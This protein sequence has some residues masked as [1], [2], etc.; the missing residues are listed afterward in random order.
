[1]DSLVTDVRGLINGKKLTVVIGSGVSHAVCSQAPTWRGLIESGIKRCRIVGMTDDW[2]FRRRGQLEESDLDSLLAVAE[3]VHGKLNKGGELGRWLRESFESLTADR[4]CSVIETL[5]KLGVPLVT[6]NYDALI[7]NVTGL[8]HVTWDDRSTVMRVVRGEDR[9]VLHLHGHWEKAE[10][11]VL[12]IRSYESVKHHEHTQTVMK[13]FGAGTSLLFV[14]CGQ[15]GLNDPN[16]GPFLEW[17]VDFDING[18]HE[19]RHYVMVRDGDPF[20]KRGRIFPLRYGPDFS[21]LAGFLQRLLPEDKQG[22]EGS[23][24]TVPKARASLVE[25]SP[26]VRAY[27]QRLEGQTEKLTLTGMGRGIPVELPIAEAYV[28]LRTRLCRSF[29]EREKDR[30]SDGREDFERDVQLSDVF[31]FCRADKQRGALLLGEPG[32]GKTT[33]ARQLA[34]QLASGQRLPED[35][36]LPA[37]IAPVLL[38]FRNLS[39]KL[40]AD[41][42]DG[43]RQFLLQETHSKLARTDEQDPGP[44]LWN[45]PGGLLWILD[46]L[47]EVMDPAARAKVAGWVKDALAHRPQDWFLVTSRFQGYDRTKFSL[48]AK[49]AEFE[50]K[51]LERD[52]IADFVS[53]WFAVVYRYLALSDAEAQSRAEADCEALLRILDKPVN[54]I[55]KMAELS[56]N[57]LLLTILCIVFYDKRQ[58]PTGRAELYA[59]CI[60]VLLEDWRQEIYS[61]GKNL[62]AEHQPYDAKAAQLVL[63]QVAWWMHQEQDRTASSMEELAA[64]AAKALAVL[65]PTAGLGRDGLVFV[66]RM[67]EEA[68]ILAMSGEGDGHCGFLHKTFQEYLAA[69]YAATTNQAKF[70]AQRVSQEWWRE[71]ALLSLRQSR[72]HCADFFAEMLKAGVAETDPGLAEQCLN[73]A[74]VF[75]PEPFL[76]VLKSRAT[77]PERR[78]AVLRLLRSRVEQ[79]PGLKEICRQ[80]E[81]STDSQVASLAKEIVRVRRDRAVEVVLGDIEAS[82]SVEDLHEPPKVAEPG[83]LWTDDRTGITYIWIPPGQFVMGSDTSKWDDEKPAHWV[84]ISK[85]FW[86]GRYPVTNSQYLKY[87]ASQRSEEHL[88]YWNDRRFNQPEQPVV[89]VSWDDATAFAQWA[90]ARLP[91]EA[92]WEYACRAGSTTKYCFGDDVAQLGDYAWFGDN[93]NGQTQPVGTKKPNA[94]GL[95]DMLGNVWEWCQDWYDQGYYQSSREVDPMG[96]ESGSLRCLRG[97]SGW[98]SD[99]WIF[100][101]ANRYWNSPSYRDGNLGFRLAAVPARAEPIPAR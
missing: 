5:G 73:E 93:S 30:F 48:G 78:A 23:V 34:W 7:E 74:M 68:G 40:L 75:V 24:V 42:H 14:G 11:V 58:L 53:K 63:A 83:S 12:G 62:P 2:C 21:D 27:L 8:K 46:G 95:H 15:E 3:L 94:W 44:E 87:L 69:E 43:L 41:G 99:A 22:D 28:P 6:T 91:S 72:Q 71:A 13:L 1:M 50:V 47:D 80:L 33:G 51:P 65:L 19:H 59:Q 85:P 56:A 64:E 84:T 60:R 76:K 89:G 39:S 100:R 32:A 31:Q 36:G 38:K 81:S 4:D 20:E 79:V 10:S 29:M 86:L 66:K 25:H 97:G 90:Q 88:P 61:D 92:E 77:K 26:S 49:F 17:L 37:G 45:A 96:P 35:L 67:R 98:G 52:Q 57:P 9:R 70:L 18:K 101:S 16:W 82:V 55:G 54:Q